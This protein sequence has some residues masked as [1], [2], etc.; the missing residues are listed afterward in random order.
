MVPRHN[1]LKALQGHTSPAPQVSGPHVSGAVRQKGVIPS[2]A[3]QPRS[4]GNPTFRPCCHRCR[5]C[6]SS[7][8]VIL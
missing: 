3:A 4:R 5:C 1:R 6:P 7:A 8:S 2:E